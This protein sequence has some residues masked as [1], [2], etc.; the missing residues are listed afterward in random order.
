MPSSVR[1]VMLPM[2]KVRYTEAQ[3]EGVR[4]ALVEGVRKALGAEPIAAPVLVESERGVLWEVW[5]TEALP[6]GGAE[7]V[8]KA[9]DAHSVPPWRTFPRLPPGHVVVVVPPS[10]VAS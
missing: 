2:W 10:E 6:D 5:G 9:R 8:L 4:K 3:V 7:I 1:S